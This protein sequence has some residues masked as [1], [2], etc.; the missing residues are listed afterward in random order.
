MEVLKWILGILVFITVISI[1]I[2]LHE[3][4]HLLVAKKFKI[5]VPKY[6][7]GFGPTVW[8]MKKGETEYGIKALPLGG[9][10]LV[11]DRSQPEDSPERALLSYVAPWKRILIFAAG[12]MVNIVLGVSILFGL[13]MS[14]P[15]YVAGTTIDR[16]ADCSVNCA[17]TEAGFLPGDKIIKVDGKDVSKLE[18][19]QGF[20]QTGSEVIILRDGKE[21]TL[22]PKANE[23][24]MIGVN[25][26]YDSHDRTVSESIS[27]I[28]TMFKLNAHT[29]AS[30]PSKVPNLIDSITGSAARDRESISSVVG[31]GRVYGETAASSEPVKTKTQMFIYYAAML[32]LGLGLANFLPLIPL[33]GGRIF[34]AMMDSVKLNWSKLR[35]KSYLPVHYKWVTAMTGVFGLMLFSFMGLVIIADIVAPISIK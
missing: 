18:D 31:V 35:K 3:A 24:N 7:V 26:K 25:M 2:A 34:I 9:F 29:L 6:F 4:G 22:T 27:T 12:P 32:N 33:D 23:R 11:E 28:G 5:S 16:L 20:K 13:L 8:S 10:I 15:A 21:L 14:M 1:S 19:I 30:V 17:A